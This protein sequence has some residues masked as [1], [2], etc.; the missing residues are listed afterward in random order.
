MSARRTMRGLALGLAVAMAASLAAAE[1]RQFAGQSL[2]L[3]AP[4]GFCQLDPAQPRDR[5]AI[6]NM[7]QLQAGRNAVALLFADCGELGDFRA[8]KL[9][10]IPHGGSILLPLQEGEVVAA[11]GY[12]RE[13]FLAEATAQFPSMDMAAVKEEV[14][15]R[16]KK[17]GGS[18]E[19]AQLEMLGSLRQDETA[20]YLGFLNRAS[21]AN[22]SAVLSINAMTLV[23]LL[24]VSIVMVSPYAGEATIQDLLDRERRALLDL[25]AA[26]AAT[27]GSAQAGRWLG[28]DWRSVGAAALTGAVIASLAFGLV[29]L[30]RRR[31]A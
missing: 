3:A 5:I 24:P 1:K 18:V 30:I 31:R 29:A 23:N 14:T 6:Q 20:I 2:E 9:D 26:N 4:Q 13:K 21:E 19:A 7:E 10:L 11:R 28:V 15:E 8:G 25:I 17:A 27:D 12:T 16:I 22:A